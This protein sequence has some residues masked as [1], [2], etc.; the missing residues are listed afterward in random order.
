MPVLELRSLR[1]SYFSGPPRSPRRTD[2]LLGVDLDVDRGEILGIVGNASSGKTTL[3]LC[4]AGLLQRDGG[5]IRWYGERFPGGGC[6]PGL[7]YVPAVP[8]YYPFLTVRDVLH[9]YTAAERES[10]F[11]R[12]RQIDSVAQRLSLTDFL[13][14]PAGKLDNETLK[15]VAIAQALVDDPK[16]VL[17]DGSLD[18]LG[19]GAASVHR[20]IRQFAAGG[21]TVIATSREAAFLAGVATRIVVIDGGWLTGSFSAVGYARPD[22]TIAAFPPLRQIAERIH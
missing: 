13:A 11:F 2:A 21:N 16:V 3:L 17:L 1:K 12:V 7:V 22:A 10:S 20:T 15:R 18:A 6:L 14:T 4:A 8:T 9:Y 5:S 19:S